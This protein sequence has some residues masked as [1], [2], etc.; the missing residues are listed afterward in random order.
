MSRLFKPLMICLLICLGI[1]SL[2]AQD[3]TRVRV[4]WE[5]DKRNPIDYV[6]YADNPT[7]KEQHVVVIFDDLIGYVPSIREPAGINIKTGRSKLFTLKR[8]ELTGQPNF[9]YKYYVYP[10][11][12]NPKVKK[13]EYAMPLKAN[14]RALV[15]RL[16]SSGSLVQ[17]SSTESYYGLVF[18]GNLRDTTYAARAGRVTKVDVTGTNV[19][20]VRHS[21]GTIGKYSAFLENTAMVKE[22]DEILAGS[23]LALFSNSGVY[24]SVRYLFYEFQEGVRNTNWYSFKYVVPKFRTDKGLEEL[25]SDFTYTAVLNSDLITQ[26]MTKRQR[27]NYLKNKR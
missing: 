7:S 2:Q 22:G 9:R 6:I 12:A 10:G 19:I 4:F 25:Q 27:K 15:K 26:E 24:F 1:I 23:P 3:K 13:V 17:K 20:E 11:V 16:N 5:E 8:D 14:K 21:D 18:K